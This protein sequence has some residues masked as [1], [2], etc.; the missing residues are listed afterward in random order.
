MGPHSWVWDK[1][2]PDKR[3]ST[4]RGG[5]PTNSFGGEQGRVF[6]LGPDVTHRRCQAKNRCFLYTKCRSQRGIIFSPTPE[7][8][9]GQ[10]EM[11]GFLGA[12]ILGQGPE[13]LS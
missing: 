4:L 11:T 9:K 5:L 13:E 6:M 1:L 10:T 12:G 3:A 7:I 2:W 8:T